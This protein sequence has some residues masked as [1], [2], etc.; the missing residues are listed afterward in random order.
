[1]CALLW[2]PRT[3]DHSEQE[4]ASA[5]AIIISLILVL[6]WLRLLLLFWVYFVYKTLMPCVY[7]VR[8]CVRLDECMM[9]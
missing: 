5:R 2:S 1:M 7:D 9:L 6:T 3:A 8:G 4:Q